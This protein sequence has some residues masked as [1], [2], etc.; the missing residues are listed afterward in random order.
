MAILMGLDQHRAQIT[1]DWVDT[2]TGEVSRARVAPAD[3]AGVRRFL[4]R[5]REPPWI[6]SPVPSKP[7]QLRNAVTSLTGV[8]ASPRIAIRTPWPCKPPACSSSIPY[9]LRIRLGNRPAVEITAAGYVLV[10]Q[11]GLIVPVR[12]GVPP[13]T[14]ATLPCR[15]PDTE[16]LPDTCWVT[17]SPRPHRVDVAVQTRAQL[18]RIDRKRHVLVR[19]AGRIQIPLRA[20]QLLRALDAHGRADAQVCHVDVRLYT[21]GFDRAD[22]RDTITA[23]ARLH[24]PDRMTPVRSNRHRRQ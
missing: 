13:A 8:G 15:P 12:V 24:H 9:A 2:S 5:F 17:Y 14:E 23:A 4:A 6:C 11:P 1:T 18:W 10:A 21:V 16:E 20:E 3:R 7:K 19:L 22:D